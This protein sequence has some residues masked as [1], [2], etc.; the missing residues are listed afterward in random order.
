MDKM[1]TIRICIGFPGSGKTTW[2]K[3]YIE[4]HRPQNKTAIVSPDAFREMINGKYLFDDS[5]EALILRMTLDCTR[6]ILTNGLD[7]IID[8]SN[9][10]L[11]AKSRAQLMKDIRR[12]ECVLGKLRVGAVLFDAPVWTSIDRRIMFPH[13]KY[14]ANH[15]TTVIL[16]MASV[17]E[18]VTDTESFDFFERAYE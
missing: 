8:E 14:D 6:L 10:I 13:G 1:N 17:F 18:P 2:A 11:T 15:W 9:Y 3:Q 7:V 5:Q 12:Y 4:K 16:N